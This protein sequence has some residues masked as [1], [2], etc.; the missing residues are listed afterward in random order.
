MRDVIALCLPAGTSAVAECMCWIVLKSKAGGCHVSLR[1]T[2][3]VVQQAATCHCHSSRGDVTRSLN[4]THLLSL[5]VGNH[6]EDDLSLTHQ[7]VKAPSGSQ[8]RVLHGEPMRLSQTATCLAYKLQLNGQAQ[9][10]GHTAYRAAAPRHLHIQ[11]PAT[12]GKPGFTQYVAVQAWH[13]S[14]TKQQ[15]WTWCC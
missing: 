12:S 9:T 7:D 15:W 10:D 11:R 14:N 2:C 6:D 8:G 3:M 13:T 1:S 4:H 5:Q